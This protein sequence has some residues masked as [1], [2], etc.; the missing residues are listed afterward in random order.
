MRIEA[1][2]VCLHYDDFLEQTIRVNQSLFDD[3]VVVTSQADAGT[4][5]VCNRYGVRTAFCPYFA[6]GE[7]FAKALAINIGLAHIKLEDWVVHLDAD[8]ALPRNAPS[9]WPTWS[10][11]PR[12]STE[13]TESIARASRIGIA[14]W[15]IP[16]PTRSITFTMGRETGCS[17][18]GS[19]TS[20]MVGMRRLVSSN[21]GTERRESRAIPACRDGTP[22]TPTCCTLSNGRGRSVCSSR[23]SRR[24]T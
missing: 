11:T 23:R 2:S 8:T 6:H 18:R 15:S 22:S 17:V 3:W 13:S 12:A 20:T 10:W 7:K 16:I 1:V 21:F 5:A 24:F 19:D 4:I 14:T 9:I